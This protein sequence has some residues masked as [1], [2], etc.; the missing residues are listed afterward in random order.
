MIHLILFAEQVHAMIPPSGAAALPLASSLTKVMVMQTSDSYQADHLA[1][2]IQRWI[3][4]SFDK[5]LAGARVG[6]FMNG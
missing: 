1:T 2:K 4:Y 3:Q 5:I 6:S